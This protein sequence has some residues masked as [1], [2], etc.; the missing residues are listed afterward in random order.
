MHIDDSPK[1]FKLGINLFNSTFWKHFFFFSPIDSISSSLAGI[2]SIHLD[3][4]TMSSSS[5]LWYSMAVRRTTSA[6]GTIWQITSQMSIILTS[7][8]GG[9]LSI[10]LMKI[11]VITSIVVR[12][13]LKAAS[14]KKGLKKVVAKVIAVR[15]RE[16]K[17][18]IIIS[19]VIFLFITMD[20]LIP[21][22]PFEK[23]AFPKFQSIF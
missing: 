19:L 9:R 20:I 16:G 11:V 2:T 1:V 21:F 6:K 17:Y 4:G 7:E 5:V 13:T 12:F 15:R 22:F 10:L 14:K 3:F 18:V 23:V 8:V